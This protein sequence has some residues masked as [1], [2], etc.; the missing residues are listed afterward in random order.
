MY[1]LEGGLEQLGIQHRI[2]RVVESH[3]LAIG[4]LPREGSGSQ[5]GVVGILIDEGIASPVGI[6]RKA[7]PGVVLEIG[8]QLGAQRIALNVAS[9]LKE[10]ALLV[11]QGTLI[12]PLPDVARVALLDFVPASIALE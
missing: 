4:D 9:R 7:R 1:R 12:A 8:H 2:I 10:V 3:E 11:H 5:L 6:D